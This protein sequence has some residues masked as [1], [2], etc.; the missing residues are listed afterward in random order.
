MPAFSTLRSPLP[1][2]RK[3]YFCS[4]LRWI[5]VHRDATNV[6]LRDV[7]FPASRF[8]VHTGSFRTTWP[9][10]NAGESVSTE[11]I[12]QPKRAGELLV[13]PAALS[14]KDGDVPRTIRLAA[15]DDIVV[16]D[17]LAYRRRTDTHRTA[18]LTF[19][20]A[21]AA[22]VGLPYLSYAR[23]MASIPVGKKRT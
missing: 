15:S 13:S 23:A 16:E 11:V 5:Y 6:R 19:V 17:L 8:T 9:R 3:S 12:A 4:P 20:C 2:P 14:Y 18:W 10:L 7:A 1:F 21:S 22:A